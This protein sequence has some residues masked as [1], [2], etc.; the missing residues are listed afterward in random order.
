[1]RELT[2]PVSI[3]PAGGSGTQLVVYPTFAGRRQENLRGQITDLATG[4]R[5]NQLFPGLRIFCGSE[6]AYA[7]T[8]PVI[9]QDLTISFPLPDSAVTRPWHAAALLNLVDY[10]T[11]PL[12]GDEEFRQADRAVL[13]T[14]A[15]APMPLP[16][17]YAD[18]DAMTKDA[19]GWIAG[20][21]HPDED[22]AESHPVWPEDFSRLSLEAVLAYEKPVS[23][24][25]A[26]ALHEIG[27]DLE[28]MAAWSAFQTEEFDMDY[29][30]TTLVP[31]A[32]GRESR[33]D[34]IKYWAEFPV[35]N[36]AVTLYLFS[37]LAAQRHGAVINSAE[38][39]IR[40]LG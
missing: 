25:A 17:L 35:G 16:G 33:V 20:L 13:K 14:D 23:A 39:D 37:A 12:D 18:L 22:L 34:A 26:K 40:D 5:E 31:Y 15:F 4:M 21:Y 7:A 28:L 32:A 10:A 30:S 8:R 1:M 11:S 38:F 19:L 27:A 24:Q 2:L 29:W 3:E 9:G 36:P 6:A